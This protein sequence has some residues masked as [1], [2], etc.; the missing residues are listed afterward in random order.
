MQ[1]ADDGRGVGGVREEELQHDKAERNTRPSARRVP[2]WSTNKPRERDSDGTTTYATVIQ[3]HPV[4]SPS[5][6]GPLSMLASRAPGR[7]PNAISGAC[8]TDGAEQVALRVRGS[9]MSVLSSVMLETLG[10]GAGLLNRARPR[11]GCGVPL[12]GLAVH[13]MAFPR[14]SLAQWRHAGIIAAVA[15]LGGAVILAACACP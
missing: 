15:P 13:L 4:V 9:L 2:P 1:H 7:A 14:R 3:A 11:S 12:S 6:T 8:W 5:E 10:R